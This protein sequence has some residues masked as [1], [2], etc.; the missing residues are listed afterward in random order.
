KKPVLVSLFNEAVAPQAANLQKAHART[1]RTTRGIQDVP[2]SS[3]STVTTEDAE[4]E[5]LLAPP[6]AT[7]RR[8]SRRTTRAPTE[9]V[10]EIASAPR[11]KTPSRAVPAKHSR[12][13]EAE[14]DERPAARRTR[15]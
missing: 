9:E 15:K 5:T 3:A 14:V 10:D 7:T 8:T 4:D 11:G 1:K 2:S 12:T 6:P 13:T